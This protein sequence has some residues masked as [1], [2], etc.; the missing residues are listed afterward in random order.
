MSVDTNS[1]VSL[2]KG[3]MSKIID[4]MNDCHLYLLKET[5]KIDQMAQYLLSRPLSI[6][7]IYIFYIVCC[8]YIYICVCVCVCVLQ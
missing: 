7:L 8:I 2:A 3:G 5:E 6:T 4:I 1:H